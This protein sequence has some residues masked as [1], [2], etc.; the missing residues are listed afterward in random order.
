MPASDAGRDSATRPGIA[1]LTRASGDLATEATRRMETT[2]PWYRDLGPQERS[3]VSLIAQT[4]I[5]AFI[6]W[7]G[8]SGQ[9]PALTAEVFGAAPRELA[10]S[11]SL[12]QTVDL[13]RTTVDVVESAIERLAVD[14]D[15][16][17]LRLA[18]LKYSREVAFSAAE[19]YARAAEARGAWDARLEA[20]VVDALLRDEV[21]EDL[22]GRV[23][24][25]GWVGRGTVFVLA[26][27]A[28]LGEVRDAL[29]VPRR[30]AAHHGLDLLTGVHG[31]TL[32]AVVGGGEPAR[33]ARLLAPHFGPGPV[34]ASAGVTALAQVPRAARSALSGLR[35]AWG[36]PDAPRPVDAD[37]LLPERALGG[38]ADAQAALVAQVHRTL[39]DDAALYDTASAYLERTGSLEATARALFIHPNTV[40]YRLRRITDLTGLSPTDARGAFTLRVGLVLGRLASDDLEA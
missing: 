26:G 4:G 11:I 39:L 8:S 17:A 38:D 12:E 10:R 15:Q 19:V 9:A 6:E 22:V 37:D 36:W 24:A 23:G 3:W 27:P 21:D 32:L 30:A 2:F 14:A 13:V 16:P 31:T 35:A 1:E 5:A 40:R 25:L 7:Y 28:P 20:L 33:A 18:A 29:D 34:V